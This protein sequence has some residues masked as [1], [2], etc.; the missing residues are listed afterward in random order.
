ML[1]ALSMV[2]GNEKI[3][4]RGDGRNGP[5]SASA[6]DLGTLK[7]AKPHFPRPKRSRDSFFRVDYFSR[8]WRPLSAFGSGPA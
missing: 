6:V 8:F 7:S 5:S 1:Q 3:R 2:V 4:K